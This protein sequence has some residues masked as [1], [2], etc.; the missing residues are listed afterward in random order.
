MASYDYDW[1]P[2]KDHLIAIG[3]VIVESASLEQVLH[4]AIWQLLGL[5]EKHGQHVTAHLRIDGLL[6]LF[7][8]LA[9]QHWCEGEVRVRLDELLEKIRASNSKRNDVAHAQWD[10]GTIESEPL[11]MRYRGE[12]LD[13]VKEYG[14]RFAATTPQDIEKVAAN[15]CAVTDD[16][17]RFLSGQGLKP[18]PMP[19]KERKPY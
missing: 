11:K 17:G 13:G 6:R 19:R 12:S 3:K 4:L 15:I 8:P 10:W 9:R 2:T 1:P 5:E 14:F 18:P 16:L 7:Q